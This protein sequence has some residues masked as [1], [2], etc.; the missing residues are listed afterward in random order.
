[1]RRLSDIADGRK[2]TRFDDERVEILRIDLQG[3]VGQFLAF[4]LVTASQSP[5]CGAHI[6]IE[7]F[8]GLSHRRIKIR[9]TNLDAQ[10]VWFGQKQLLQQGNRIGLL[11]VF[12]VQL[13]QLQE[14]RSRLRH[15]ALLHVEVSQFFERANFFRGEFGDALVNG[16]GL[17]E[18]PIADEQLCEALEVINRWA[19]RIVTVSE[20]EIATAMRFYFSDTHNVAEG[21][22][23]APL[24]AL[25]KERAAMERR[26]VGLVLSG[27][28]V[29]RE[30][31]ARVLA[32][33]RSRRSPI[34]KDAAWR[35]TSAR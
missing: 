6:H 33:Q 9:Q 34:G 24:A 8:P 12:Q 16:D 5:L 28:N 27:G 19:E 23:A 32:D 22:G 2:G 26:R 4:G 13:G 11:V 1:L 14:E 20:A 21:A 10:I 29:D 17:G 35:R 18:K 30:V 31:Y 25:L 7:G 3:L 15:D